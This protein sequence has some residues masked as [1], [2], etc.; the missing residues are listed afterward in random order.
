[1]ATKCACNCG[2]EL[3]AKCVANGWKYLLGHR[4]K[5][6]NGGGKLAAKKTMA[7]RRDASRKTFS[8]DETLDTLRKRRDAMTRAIEELEKLEW[9]RFP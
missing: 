7:G 9:L 1:M 3:S 5:N 4:P 8:F 2:G 6:G